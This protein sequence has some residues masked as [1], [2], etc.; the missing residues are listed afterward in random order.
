MSAT[1]SLNRE[2]INTDEIQIL[3][4]KIFSANNSRLISI[5]YDRESMPLT[6]IDQNNDLLYS[7]KKI[8]NF[9]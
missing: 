3:F 7:N 8:R 5:C 9:S 4:D 6:I 1:C 2:N